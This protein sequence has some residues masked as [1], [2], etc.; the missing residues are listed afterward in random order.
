MIFYSLCHNNIL[1]N[2]NFPDIY[3]TPEYG[4]ACEYSDNAE[5]ELCKYKDLIYVYLK[6]PIDCDG[7]IYY[8]LIT[9]YGYSGYYYEKLETYNE[10]IPIF[11][12]KA[13]ERD[14]VT[15][16]LRQNPY[17]NIDIAEYDIITTK[18][19]Y[20]INL[21]NLN[22][23]G[24]LRTTNKSNR[25]MINK[26]I[27]NNLEFKILEYNNKNLK[28]F[29]YVYNLTMDNLNST[30]YYYFNREYYNRLCNCFIACV[31][32]KNILCASSVIFKYNDLLHYHI[33]GSLSKYRE[34][35]CNNFLHYNVMIYGIKNNFKLYV[36]GG[37]I[38]EGDSLS[39]F[40]EKLSNKEFQYTIYKNILNQ[41]IYNK[42]CKNKNTD[43]FPP[44]R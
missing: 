5:W 32:L 15:E 30:K 3:F 11:R 20:G 19:L 6:R 29:K 13:K 24:Y 14:Y 26:A 12:K 40:K 18:T 35:G 10:F 25:R 42:L 37:G 28:D 27:K 23:A 7:K 31:Y 33:G 17:L 41:E 16:V 36:L 4:K 34:Y 39:K 21:V 44:Y 43:F 1:K 22:E 9:P 8:D 38:K 2:T